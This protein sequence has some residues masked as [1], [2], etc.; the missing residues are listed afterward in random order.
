MQ[1]GNVVRRKPCDLDGRLIRKRY[2]MR[3]RGTVWMPSLNAGGS[4]ARDVDGIAAQSEVLS[5]T[6]S[7]SFRRGRN[8]QLG[9]RATDYRIIADAQT[10]RR[11]RAAYTTKKSVVSVTGQ[12]S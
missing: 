11:R 5:T 10:R 1:L 12:Q 9:G 2:G 6:A 8:G 4:G 7:Q 3:L